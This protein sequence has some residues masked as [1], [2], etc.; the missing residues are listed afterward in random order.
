VSSRNSAIIIGGV[1]GA[2]LGATAAWAYTKTQEGQQL[3][4]GGA[5]GRPVRLQVSASEY[6]K[7]GM[8]VLTVMRQVA[9]LFKQA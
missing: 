2:A 3:Q 9:D 8:A 7:I 6:V 4:T 5:S 1:V